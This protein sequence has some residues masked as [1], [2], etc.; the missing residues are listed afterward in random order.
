MKKGV[1][2]KEGHKNYERVSNQRHSCLFYG[3]LWTQ[4]YLRGGV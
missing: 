3:M 2:W 1:F 4:A